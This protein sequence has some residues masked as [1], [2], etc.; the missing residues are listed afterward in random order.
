MPDAAQP[1]PARSGTLQAFAGTD[2]RRRVREIP[3]HPL[4]LQPSP[5]THSLPGTGEGR[6]E[7][8]FCLREKPVLSLSKGVR[9]EGTARGDLWCTWA[10]THLHEAQ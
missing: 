8:P 5:P 10:V 2:A 9:D 7:L 1:V 4:P 6:I 3:A